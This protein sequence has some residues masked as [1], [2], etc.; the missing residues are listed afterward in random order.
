MIASN[1]HGLTLS[2]KVQEIANFYKNEDT[3]ADLIKGH[4]TKVVKSTISSFN[5]TIHSL[6]NN[7][8]TP[9][10]NINKLEGLTKETDAH[11]KS[12]EFHVALQE[13]LIF[14]EFL[15]FQFQLHMN[16]ISQACLLAPKGIIH[17]SLSPLPKSSKNLEN[18]HKIVLLESSFLY[19]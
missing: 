1:A 8:K 9:I 7:E 17:S 2:A 16:S 19:Q 10:E 18:F 14:F 3:L 15:F 4:L 11:L 6:H 13:N 12:M 5:S